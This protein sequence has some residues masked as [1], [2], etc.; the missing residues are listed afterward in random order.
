MFYRQRKNTYIKKFNGNGYIV[1]KDILCDRIVNNSGTVFLFA[2][3]HE[4][5]T[6]EQLAGKILKQF[7]GVNIEVI[8]RDAQCF[9]D[10]LVS[11][12]FLVKGE[13][14]E[15]LNQNDSNYTYIYENRNSSNRE[16]IN[17]Y[18]PGLDLG[19]H[20]FYRLMIKYMNDFPYRFMENIKIASVYGSF[21]NIIWN[22]GRVRTGKNVSINEMNQMLRQLND[23]GVA[24]RYTYTNSELEEKHLSDTL[25]NLTMELANNG[26]N[27][28]L[29]NSPILE[30][31]LRKNY[32]NFRYIL[33]TTACERDV[34]KINA[35][36][37]KYDL[38]VIDYRD[39]KNFGFLSKIKNKDKIEF[40][41]D[42]KCP[43][44]CKYRKIEY[45]QISKINCL[46]IPEKE[47]EFPCARQNVNTIGFY[48][49][50]KTNQDTN[51]TFDEVYGKYY[52]MGFRHFK[53]EGRNEVDINSAFE[54]YIY[55]L[56]AP[57]VRELV[58]YDLMNY[59]MDFVINDYGGKNKRAM[60]YYAKF[61][62][63][64]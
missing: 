31:Y 3:S 22:G 46:K 48:D 14:V 47:K 60:D 39:N 44:S 21:N 62:E 63:G 17:F 4:P 2:L 50:L 64:K 5:Q 58:R 9:Y 41:I 20:N 12:G 10:D 55:Y 25:A 15:E 57:E 28:V 43:S 11:K 56:A 19:Y 18:I 30:K 51:L 36:T 42:E 6:L 29:V 37:K 53:L 35:A 26:K 49:G 24:V 38:V 34:D 1:A 8:L 13:T 16:K 52:D 7:V 40:L 61:L 45:E 54:S 59:Y 23:A 32:P 27:E 33:S